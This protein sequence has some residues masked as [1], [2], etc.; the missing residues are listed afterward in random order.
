MVGFTC[1]DPETS[2]IQRDAY[3]SIE[4]TDDS[5]LRAG[6][7]TVTYKSNQLCRLGFNTETFKKGQSLGLLLTRKSNL[8][9]F[10]DGKVQ[11]TVHVEGYPLD[12][13]M[14]GLI[15]VYGQCKQVKAEI[16]SG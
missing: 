2:N 7:T 6:F 5:L 12:K 16:C 4:G 10:L 1:Q 3:L 8:L 11:G 15:D 14:W 9:W 13:P